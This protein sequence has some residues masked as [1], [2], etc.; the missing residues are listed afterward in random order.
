VSFLVTILGSSS[1]LPTS[2]RFTSA[3]LLNA[4]ERFYLIDCGEG[5]QM[6]LRRFRLRLGK[7]NHIFISHAHGDHCLGLI[8]LLSSFNLLGHTE[9]LHIF[10]PAQVEEVMRPMI[11]FFLGQVQFRLIFHAVATKGSNLIFDDD[12]VSVY[13]LPMKHRIPTCGFLFR[14]KE[15]ERNIRKEMVSRYQLGIAEIVKIKQGADFIDE[16]GNIISNTEL[17]VPP[18]HQRSYAYC[19][20]TAYNPK[21]PEYIEGVDLLYHEATFLHKEIKRAEENYHSTAL[22]AAQIAQNSH[23]G[24]LL[25]GHYSARYKTTDALLAEAQSLFPNTDAVNDGDV[26]RVE[27]SREQ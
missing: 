1:A 2:Q 5:T 20:D 22:Q 18:M 17:T 26:F 10:A 15:K 25:I 23:A 13:S 27:P 14:E 19:S 24:R 4:G 7:I 8:G 11:D 12:K 9:D 21:L 6:Q 3:H 16:S